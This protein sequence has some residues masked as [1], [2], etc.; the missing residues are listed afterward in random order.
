[1]NERRAATPPIAGY[2]KAGPS[3]KEV[4]RI[5]SWRRASRRDIRPLVRLLPYVL[6]HKRDAVLGLAFLVI[7]AGSMLALTAGARRIVDRGLLIHTTG[8]LLRE[9]SLLGAIVAVL[10]LTTGL[11]LYFV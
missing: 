3:M 4:M 1:M 10:A 5:A 2:A 6:A 8:D 9:F 11:R 7:S